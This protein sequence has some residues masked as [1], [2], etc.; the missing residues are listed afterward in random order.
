MLPNGNG[1][2]IPLCER[3]ELAGDPR[4]TR[5]HELVLV[6]VPIFIEQSLKVDDLV[7]LMGFRPKTTPLHMDLYAHFGC[8]RYT[9]TCT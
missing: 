9:S 8:R 7:R 2:W 4:L 1:G 6:G 3:D 5:Y